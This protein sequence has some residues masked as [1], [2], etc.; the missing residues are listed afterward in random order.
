MMFEDEKKFKKKYKN[1][2]FLFEII[3]KIEHIYVFLI[4]KR[5]QI[6]IVIKTL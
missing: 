2:F 1:V 5:N 3:N 4:K 6:N